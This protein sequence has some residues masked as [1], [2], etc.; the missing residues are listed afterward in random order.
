[1]AG[2]FYRVNNK[3]MEF[4]LK[5]AKIYRANRFRKIL[6]PTLLKLW[7]ALCLLIGLIT[8]IAYLGSAE[9]NN[10]VPIEN[11]LMLGLSL[12][13]IP[14]G[15]FSLFIQI[16]FNFYLKYPKIK[17]EE[18]IADLLDFDS[19]LILDKSTSIRSLSIALLGYKPAK[20]V[21]LRIGIKT[22]QLKKIISKDSYIE[23]PK[24]LI[25]F[26]ADANKIREQH[27][28][29]RITV[30][31]LI[32]SLFD[33]EPIFKQLLIDQNLD[34]SDLS[35]L[36][37]WHEKD[38][39]YWQN[40]A[41]FW[42][43]ENLLRQSPIGA[44]WAYGYPLFLQ[45]FT[46]DITLPFY[47]KGGRVDLIGRDKVMLQIEQALAKTQGANVLL[48]G[49]TGIGKRSIVLA[50]AQKVSAGE[51]L[52]AI[53]Y[54]RI[55]ELNAPL[56]PSFSENEGIAQNIIISLLNEATKVG[57]AVLFIDDLHET[58]ISRI[59]MPFL[60]STKIQVIATTDPRSFHKHAGISSS[61]LNV[62]TKISIP[63]LDTTSVIKIIEGLIP[64]AELKNKIFFTYS[65]IK[66]IVDDAD[67]YIQSTPFPK[68]AVDLLDDVV[69]YASSKKKSL[70]LAQDVH[71]VITQKTNIPVGEIMSNERERL[72]RLE[73]EMHKEI[74]GQ[75]KAVK[76]VAQTMMRLRSG[77]SKR[78][79][80]AGVFLFMGPTGV[81]K[82][83][84]AKILAK[85][86]F[87]SQD[88]MVRFD[89]SEYQTLNSID[90]LLGSIE[91]NQP[92]E[93]VSSVRDNPFSL[94]LLDE[95]EKA[96]KDILNIFLQIF[97]EGR[98][99]DAFGRKVNFE[100]NIIIATSNAGAAQIRDMINQGIDPSLHKENVINILIQG[101]YFSPELLN[102]FDEIVVF[103]PLSQ[104]H[105]LKIS[106]IL[107]NKLVDRLRDAGYFF[108]PSSEIINYIATIGF[109]PQFGARPMNRAVQ[110]KIES[111]IAKKI[112][113]KNI[114]KGVEFSLKVEELEN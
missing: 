54:K 58:D 23:N 12:I 36:A 87:G 80:P 107:I 83:L 79:K 39:E 21:F 75:E 15:L 24:T 42:R 40:R 37:L 57:N 98:V 82:T 49:E 10:F 69:S 16:F 66:M 81:G 90:K 25:N 29:E 35:E 26:L 73:E 68:K 60:E 111:A 43:I 56:I 110:D 104:E 51:A 52:P 53:N 105:V 109:D 22:D 106:G 33:F 84:T 45:R 50:L 9:I 34:K 5:K 99:T 28:H 61:I 92:G 38:K 91:L 77:L 95:I 67:K 94:L 102:R 108:A 64:Q 46:E 89:M 62:F 1:M 74:I 100:Q 88:R 3:R 27:N 6:H 31:D 113:E 72:I 11:S 93:L 7:G 114:I 8:A 78:G 14:L 96:H 2:Y 17:S 112:L 76:V 30:P 55:F 59:L 19:V 4:N 13:F 18:N 44:S 47:E 48:V 103:H 86:Y 20:T 63:E 97:D 101:G 71:D 70:I 41:K 32:A 65:A 85:T